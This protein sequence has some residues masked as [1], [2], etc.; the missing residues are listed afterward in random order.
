MSREA[1]G[2]EVRDP[3]AVYAEAESGCGPDCC[4]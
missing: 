3:L 1:A 2:V 4:G